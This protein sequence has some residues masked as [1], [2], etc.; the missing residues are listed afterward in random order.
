MRIAWDENNACITGYIPAQR[1]ANKGG[2]LY[3]CITGSPRIEKVSFV[4]WWLR[5]T[6]AKWGKN[7]GLSYKHVQTKIV[8]VPDL[9]VVLQPSAISQRW[10]QYGD[11]FLKRK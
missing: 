9:L 6:C 3:V 5:L 10:C 2:S 11:N 8:S 1:I 7:L 4:P